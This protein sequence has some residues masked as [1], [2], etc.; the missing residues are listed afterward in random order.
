[1]SKQIRRRRGTT[2]QHGSFVGA[3]GEITV[4]TTK[5]TVVVHDGSTPGGF[6]LARQDQAIVS[7]QQ[8]IL[9]AGDL[10]EYFK[11]VPMVGA[12]TPRVITSATGLWYGGHTTHGDWSGTLQQRKDGTYG[13]GGPAE[14]EYAPSGQYTLYNSGRLMTDGS[15]EGFFTDH[16]LSSFPAGYEFEVAIRRTFASRANFTGATWSPDSLRITFTSNPSYTF[17]GNDWIALHCLTSL[18]DQQIS[19]NNVCPGWYRIATYNGTDKV[20]LT[21]D[22]S[23]AGPTFCATTLAGAVDGTIFQANDCA[24]YTGTTFDDTTGAIY[25]SGANFASPGSDDTVKVLYNDGTETYVRVVS[26]T[27]PSEIIVENDPPLDSALFSGNISVFTRGQFQKKT[28][29]GWQDDEAPVLWSQPSSPSYQ[30]SQVFCSP[31][32]SSP[33][34][35]DTYF[36]Y[37]KNQGSPLPESHP[38]DV[39]TRTADYTL[40]SWWPY[41]TCN[42]STATSGKSVSGNGNNPAAE[43]GSDMNHYWW[44]S[45]V[46]PRE[47]FLNGSMIDITTVA[48]VTHFGTPFFIEV[49]VI[50]N[51]DPEADWIKDQTAINSER[52]DNRMIFWFHSAIYR[53]VELTQRI[54]PTWI[55]LRGQSG[56]IQTIGTQQGLNPGTGDNSSQQWLCE[57]LAGPP[58]NFGSDVTHFDRLPSVI[59]PISHIQEL[60]S[61]KQND[62][63]NTDITYTVLIKAEHASMHGY[64]GYHGHYSNE[65]YSC[66][67]GN[68]GVL[69]HHLGNL[70]SAVDSNG[71]S[72]AFSRGLVVIPWAPR[73]R[74]GT[75]RVEWRPGGD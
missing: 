12:K 74:V 64:P 32:S 26:R 3:A 42:K 75:F 19:D 41:F 8:N 30:V 10:N 35:G 5:N 14:L 54:V 24:Y 61:P 1:M 58:G 57:F 59:G 63:T 31:L 51:F 49:A 37:Y 17:T 11:Y 33:R 25:K 71:D 34:W 40:Q 21:V 28:V 52:F 9:H 29:T 16:G 2:G 23:W 48:D 15:P 22:D 43:I 66:T 62:T 73:F 39:P 69:L 4:D 70:P 7:A 36:I 53:P 60:D 27:S 46:L 18:T 45:F 65:P 44:G 20:T 13:S 47:T 50:P 6:A 38:E 68:G 55:R 72:I 67:T 56:Y